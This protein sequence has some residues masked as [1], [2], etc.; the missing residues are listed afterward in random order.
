[1][2]NSR[3]FVSRGFGAVRLIPLRDPRSLRIGGEPI[4][5]NLTAG[6]RGAKTAQRRLEAGNSAFGGRGELSFEPDQ[7]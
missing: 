2:S 5:E 4:R 7:A 6:R 3:G 1:V